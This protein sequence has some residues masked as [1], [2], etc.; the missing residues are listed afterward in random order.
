M[1]AMVLAAQQ[2]VNA[3]YS[4][5][6]GYKTCPE[7]GTTGW[8]VMYSLTRALQLELGLTSMADAFGPS[9]TAAMDAHGPVTAS[10]ANSNIRKIVQAALYCKGYP[11]RRHRRHLG[12]LDHQR[13]SVDEGAHGA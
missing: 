12:H 6:S 4:G 1:D 10:T 2:W 9:T 3:Q 7:T 13:H 8:S 11:G 5:R